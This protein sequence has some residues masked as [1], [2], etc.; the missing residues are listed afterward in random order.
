MV[1]SLA[2]GIEILSII[3]EKGSATIVEVAAVL[4]VDKSTVSRLMSTLM[5]YDMI[6]IDPVSKKYRLGFRILYL[7]EGVKKNFNIATAARP[8]LYKI[9][10]DTKE[11][12]HLAALGNR[13]MYIVDQ[14]RSQREYNLSAQI[15]MIEAWHCS[16]V[17]K[18]VLA[19]KPQSFIEDIFRDYDFRRYTAN[20]IATYQD[21]EKELKKIKEE[22]YALDD[23]ERTLGVRCIAVPIFSYGGNVNCCIGISAPKEQITEATLKR[24]TL[25]M[26]KYGSQISKELGYGL[27]RS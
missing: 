12:V 7:G 19:H 17:G 10:D 16:A 24:Y 1:Q 27:Y 11:S 4:G 25:C 18:C 26:K 14:V 5:H 15:G 22:G 9:C 6:S 23:E 21:L 2:R 3:Q 8:Y 13:K 20:T